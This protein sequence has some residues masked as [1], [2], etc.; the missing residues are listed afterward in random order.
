MPSALPRSIRRN[1]IPG[2]C[3]E[4]ILEDGHGRRRFPDRL[5]QTC[6]W[7][8]RQI[9]ACHLTGRRRY[10]GQH[11]AGVFAARKARASSIPAFGFW[12][13]FGLRIQGLRPAPPNCFP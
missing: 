6:P 7:I 9:Y 5:G 3:R 4:P 10:L 11:D 2:S 8:G 1:T 13:S 12:I